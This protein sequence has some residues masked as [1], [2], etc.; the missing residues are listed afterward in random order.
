MLLTNEL[1]TILLLPRILDIPN[2]LNAA[3]SEVNQIMMAYAI[4]RVGMLA[5]RTLTL[6]CILGTFLDLVSHEK[7]HSDVQIA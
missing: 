1:P 7:P 4:A 6:M 2:D 5:D 3:V